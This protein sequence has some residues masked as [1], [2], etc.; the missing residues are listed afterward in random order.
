[1]RAA[2]LTILSLLLATEANAQSR[3]EQDPD[4]A[5][6]CVLNT[7]GT[8]QYQLSLDRRFVLTL[9]ALRPNRFSL[10]SPSEQCDDGIDNNCNGELEEGCAQPPAFWGAGQDCERCMAQGCSE[11]SKPCQNDHQCA[12]AAACVAQA[13]CLDKYIGPLSCICGEGVSIAQCQRVTSGQIHAGPC[14]QEL[15][16]DA[17]PPSDSM[18]GKQLANRSLTCMGLKC[19]SA[20]SKN[21]YNYDPGT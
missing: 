18:R 10:V 21:I 4:L 9:T 3:H 14:A 7:D 17:S 11:W 1:M 12:T 6:I 13:Q 15:Y 5:Q 20:C 8:G 16:E 2:S 19:A